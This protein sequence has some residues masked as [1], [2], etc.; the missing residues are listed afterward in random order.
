MFW[1]L[2]TKSNVIPLTLIVEVLRFLTICLVFFFCFTFD[3]REI[4]YGYQL[5][6]SIVF[7]TVQQSLQMLVWLYDQCD[8]L[9]PDRRPRKEVR[10]AIK[11]VHQEN[12]ITNTPKAVMS[13]EL[14]HEEEVKSQESM[15]VYYF[16][17]NQ[18]SE[19]R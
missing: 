13:P 17:E 7:Y 2:K 11:I 16:N 6:F 5:I 12:L 4:L 10:P 14:K 1:D 19:E 18:A 8:K 9:F 3:G 15:Q